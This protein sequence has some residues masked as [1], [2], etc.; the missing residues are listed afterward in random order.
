MEKSVEVYEKKSFELFKK[1]DQSGVLQS[2]L[3]NDFEV[4]K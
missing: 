2:L 4:S 3:L 1:D